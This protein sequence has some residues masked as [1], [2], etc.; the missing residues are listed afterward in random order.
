MFTFALLYGTTPRGRSKQEVGEEEAD[1]TEQ[2]GDLDRD[3]TCR[4]SLGVGSGRELRLGP[5]CGIGLS[6]AQARGFG[7]LLCEPG[8]GCLGL[9]ELGAHIFLGYRN[10]V[11]HSSRGRRHGR[12]YAA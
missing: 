7:C 6:L 12:T 5:G 8:N 1:Q 3:T 9:C 10:G 11:G 2:C 4:G